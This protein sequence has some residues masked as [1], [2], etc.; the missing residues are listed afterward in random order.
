MATRVFERRSPEGTRVE[1]V[2]LLDRGLCARVEVPND[3]VEVEHEQA[4]Q[5]SGLAARHSRHV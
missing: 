2:L 5:A 1:S 3:A 4:H